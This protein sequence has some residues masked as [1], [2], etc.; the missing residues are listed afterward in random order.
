MTEEKFR[1]SKL[2][3]KHIDILKNLNEV[4]DS[5]IDYIENNDINDVIKERQLLNVSLTA[6]D[7]I[8]ESLHPILKEAHMLFEKFKLGL[9]TL[10][11]DFNPV[12][13]GICKDGMDEY[14]LSRMEMAYQEFVENYDSAIRNEQYDL[15]HWRHVETN[16]IHP[17]YITSYG[18]FRE[19]LCGDYKH[20]NNII[21]AIIRELNDDGSFIIDICISNNLDYFPPEELW[22]KSITLNKFKTWFKEEHPK[23]SLDVKKKLFKLIK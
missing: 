18:A 20:D 22:P 23:I 9:H 15:Q 1:V 19:Y 4:N 21:K 6:R 13:E 2:W 17:F 3:D 12:A 7:K 5:M 10:K 14:Y 16:N 8:T 11:N